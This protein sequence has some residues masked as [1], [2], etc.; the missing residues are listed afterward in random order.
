MKNISNSLGYVSSQRVIMEAGV[1]YGQ[2][3]LV[4]GRAEEAWKTGRCV[5]TGQV[6]RV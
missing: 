1:I 4:G 2:Q 3:L 6:I 5:N